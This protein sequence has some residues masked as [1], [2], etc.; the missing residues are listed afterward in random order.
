M[1]QLTKQKPSIHN[2]IA[3]CVKRIHDMRDAGTADVD[4]VEAEYLKF[5]DRLKDLKVA[6]PAKGSL[7]EDAEYSKA[8]FMD[9]DEELRHRHAQA[10]RQIRQDVRRRKR[11]AIKDQKRHGG[12]IKLWTFDEMK[13]NKTMKKSANNETVKAT[14]A[15]LKREAEELKNEK[16]PKKEK[17]EK[18]TAKKATAKKPD[19]KASKKAD[20]KERGSAI[21]DGTITLLVKENPKREGS[22]AHKRYE[23]YRK[24]KNIAAYLKAGGKRSSLRY[25]S[26]HEYIKL[27]NVKTKAELKE[28]EDK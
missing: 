15:E 17:T 1:P 19:K 12:P 23:L 3:E 8:E 21:A 13:G 10:D 20:K 7:K 22:S 18:K 26:K 24:H 27:S 25:D 6:L 9:D 28:K 5:C 14:K 2:E 4:P 11:L 16:A